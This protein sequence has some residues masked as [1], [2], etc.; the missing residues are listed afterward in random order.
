[1]LEK[2]FKYEK[3]FTTT[4]AAASNRCNKI[5]LYMCTYRKHHIVLKTHQTAIT[6]LLLLFLSLSLA[7]SRRLEAWNYI[8]LYTK[9]QK[10]EQSVI[11]H[12]FMLHTSP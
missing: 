11:D 12:C 2:K 3:L 5:V 9:V 1:M 8:Y 4:A 6:F 10:I 7:Y